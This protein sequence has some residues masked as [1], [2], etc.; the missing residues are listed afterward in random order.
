MYTIIPKR[1]QNSIFFES[2]RP[3]DAKGKS[4][5]INGE[6]FPISVSQSHNNEKNVCYTKNWRKLLPGPYSI[7]RSS[8][9]IDIFRPLRRWFRFT[10]PRDHQVFTPICCVTKFCFHCYH[11][12]NLLCLTFYINRTSGFDTIFQVASQVLSLLGIREHGL[13]Q[14]SFTGTIFL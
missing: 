11:S 2:V 4:A 8:V 14:S 12:N 7:L 13:F 5:L 1:L 6:N 3:L 10:A 9:P